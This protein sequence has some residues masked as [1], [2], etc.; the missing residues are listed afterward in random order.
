VN[1]IGD[2][3]TVIQLGAGGAPNMMGY[4]L[5]FAQ[6]IVALAWAICGSFRELVTESGNKQF[7][8]RE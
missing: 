4:A 8:E 2:F 3:S 5:S 7:V 1:S 6:P